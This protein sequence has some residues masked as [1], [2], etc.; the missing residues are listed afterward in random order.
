MDY[1]PAF[2]YFQQKTINNSGN[3]FK[4]YLLSGLKEDR[5]FNFLSNNSRK[6]LYTRKN[7]IF[8]NSNQE[9]YS[10]LTLYKDRSNYYRSDQDE[11]I[12][13]NELFQKYKKGSVRKVISYKNLVYKIAVH[14]G[15]DKA[16]SILSRKRNFYELLFDHNEMEKFIFT[17]DFDKINILEQELLDKYHPNRGGNIIDFSGKIE[18]KSNTSISSPDVTKDEYIEI[19]LHGIKFNIYEFALFQREWRD[20]NAANT[21]YREIYDKVIMDFND[22][23]NYGKKRYDTTLFYRVLKDNFLSKVN[24]FDVCLA[25][26]KIKKLVLQTNN[27]AFKKHIIEKLSKVEF[28]GLC[29]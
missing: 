21:T 16:T 12:L 22:P 13:K 8:P 10:Y 11:K 25:Y 14:T 1:Q 15:L 29:K 6:E 4:N 17:N 5:D 9:L 3:L 2:E 24:Y 20:C 18:E 28:K 7:N 23:Y 27:T 19:V 26:N